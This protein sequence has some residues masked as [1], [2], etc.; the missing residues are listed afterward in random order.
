MSARG[1]MPI[2]LRVFVSSPG[3]VAA[4]RAVVRS[5]VEQLQYDP[6][7][8]GRVTFEVVAWDQPGGGAPMT[9]TETPQASVNRGL[10]RPSECDIVVVVLW[11]RMGTPL[12]FP[13][14]TRPD[15]GPYPSGT[16][17]EYEDA[18][19][20]ARANGRP[21]VLVYR[22][23]SKVLLDS[24]AGDVD[25]QLAQKRL[26]DAFFARM[27]DERTGA[28]LGGHKKYGSPEGLRV[29]FEHDLKS[30]VH[31][32]VTAAPPAT[33]PVPRTDMAPAW[34]G[35]P[36]PGLRAFTPVDAPIFF[37]RGRET[38][39][40]AAR[41]A[42]SGF[43]AVVG[44]SGSGKSSLVGAGLIARL[45]ESG[46]GW[47][48]PAYDEDGGRWSGLRFTPGEVGDDPFL[49]VAA[50]LA[51]LTGANPAAVA[52]RLAAEPGAVVEYL[53]AG[54]SLMF[55]D[56]F[57]E[58][59]TM[60]EPGRVRLWVQLVE[61]AAL[62]GRCHVVVTLRADF[63]HRCLQVPQ[64]ARLL[65]AG[66]LPLGAPTDTL[67][68]MI[69]RP[70]ERA[71][72]RFEEGLAGRIVRDTGGDPD[73][74]PLLAYT[75]DELYRAGVHR[76]GRRDGLLNLATYE[77]LGGVQGAIGTRAENVFTG[78][79]DDRARAAFS[80]VFRELV[81]V[82][83]N[84]RS[85]RRRPRLA[86]ITGGRPARRLIEVFTQARLLVQSKDE[87]DQPV[88]YV[89]HEALFGSWR[90]LADWVQAVRDDLLLEHK[91]TAA[92]AEWAE[93]G[94]DEAFR[95]PHERLEP[96]YAMVQRLGAE[97]D[98][99]T[100]AFVEPEHERLFPV[101]RDAAVEGY[102]RQ[103]AMDRL[104]VIGPA[105]VPGL[106]E[107]VEDP[108]PVVRDAA[109]TVLARLGEPA[110]DGLVAVLG[111][112]GPDARL[113]AVGA[114]R[115]ANVPR[116]VRELA[117]A[118]RDEDARV[119]SAAVGA[120]G[121]LGGADARD[122][123]GSAVTDEAA[124]VRW[125]AAGAL[126]A[127]GPDAVPHL[128]AA[129]RTDS[130]AAEQ[131]SRAL[132]AIGERAV[133]P[134]LD[135]LTGPD[136]DKR[137]NASAAL[138]ALGASAVPRL[139]PLLADDDADVRWRVCDILAAIGD[140]GAAEPL[141]AVLEDTEPAVRAAAAY[142]LAKVGAA[143]AV[144]ALLGALADPD[145]D[146]RW[147]VAD[148]LAE[149]SASSAQPLLDALSAQV[150]ATP[151]VSA[152]LGR[153][154]DPALVSWLRSDH[155][156]VR[157]RVRDVLVT[158]GEPAVPVL[159]D[160]LADPDP[161]VREAAA[162]TLAGIGSAAV[163]GLIERL[164]SADPLVRSAAARA[165]GWIAAEERQTTWPLGAPHPHRA[166]PALERL[167]GDQ[168]AACRDAAADALARFGEHAL[169]VVWRGL[170]APAAP[171]REAAVRA[172]V[173]IGPAAVPGLLSIAA[174]AATAAQA[175]AVEALQAIATPAALFG[176]TE[177]G[178]APTRA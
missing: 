81:R 101:L 102:R 59:F 121:A 6:F 23:T 123:L 151:M 49:A 134:L 56:Q 65:E 72:L 178:V 40:L 98:A 18:V 69:A 46:S 58:L 162:R 131:V 99:V 21:K 3:D 171:T 17:W 164:G 52:Q 47:A 108:S 170:A 7:V 163:P 90:R 84:G 103:N 96:V 44:A 132:L 93:H 147:A 157:D 55:V 16:E 32:V 27:R 36:F 48:L 112:G 165:L 30:L 15:G 111:R 105:T 78:L 8:R 155:E 114:L 176:L 174:E 138:A 94:R 14:Y 75:L 141:L 119:R 87:A 136:T 100:A 104:V 66:Q 161:T 20:G 146:V 79:L 91:V 144:P 135:G 120:L 70:A 35:S 117:P 97:L 168:E 166:L 122:L 74:L 62:S 11:S 67:H 82:D 41:V 50:R 115:L 31:D 172:A 9:A 116:A 34:E 33:A 128:L 2:H 140:A 153:C 63:Y 71:D 158:W 73:A 152:A 118:L 169:P 13:E 61:A 130:E 129:S 37:G 77:R 5:V 107:M 25:R 38:D 133:E 145:H 106:L 92:A 29:E 39:E 86:Q 85:T 139:V 149:L 19:R 109:A 68:D 24:D 113:A 125:L 148:A 156:P 95:W 167:L 177:L 42:A 124:D 28:A 83:E 127:F 53:P 4:E 1:D 175:P 76:D 12:P 142:A 159:L 143:P 160:L 126:G 88:V 54:T 43:V 154:T 60:V 26:V 57:E 150:P 22:R 10:P 173:R 80:R 137:V 45:R 64:L 89:A 110:V 51:P